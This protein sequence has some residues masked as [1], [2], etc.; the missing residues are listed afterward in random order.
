MRIVCSVGY[1]KYKKVHSDELL[2]FLGRNYNDILDLLERNGA[3]RI[4]RTETEYSTP[5]RKA[6][7]NEI[8]V[9]GRR[10]SFHKVEIITPEAL[11]RI[12]RFKA[13]QIDHT[14]PGRLLNLLIRA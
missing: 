8:A 2:T 7:H 12:R 1:S 3:I 14:N 4:R 10:G 9:V 5:K 13:Q 6:F 11:K